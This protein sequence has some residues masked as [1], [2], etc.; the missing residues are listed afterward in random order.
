ML[1]RKA[2]ILLFISQQ[3]QNEQAIRTELLPAE[4]TQG[5]EYGKP[6]IYYQ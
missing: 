6:V 5:V 3:E 4:A 2:I 1:K